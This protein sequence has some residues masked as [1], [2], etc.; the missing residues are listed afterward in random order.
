MTVWFP[1]STQDEYQLHLGEYTGNAGNALVNTHMAPAE[2]QSW[3]FPGIKFSTYDHLNDSESRCVRH[4]KSGWWF[5]RWGWFSHPTNTPDL[6]TNDQKS[7]TGTSSEKLQSDGFLLFFALTGATL[8]TWTA[9]TTTGRT[10]PW[11]TT[12]W[13][14]S[15]GTAGGT[16]LSLWSWWCELTTSSIQREPWQAIQ[17]ECLHDAALRTG[18][19]YCLCL[20]TW[21]FL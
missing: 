12:V 8:E 11:P 17:D 15:P 6:Q 14:G 19:R 2:E 18:Y 21:F 5:S 13:C 1:R 16:P 4:S 3:P 10:R 20:Y 7:H 9:I